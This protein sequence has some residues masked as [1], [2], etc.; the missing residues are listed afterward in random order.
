MT[1]TTVPEPVL[2]P[3]TTPRRRGG[4]RRGQGWAA[5]FFLIPW[6]AGI[7]LL[8][9]GPM[10]YSLYLSFTSYD[11]LSAPEWVGLANYELMLADPRFW[12]SVRVTLVYVVV[13][14]PLLQVVSMLVALL[15][16]S[17]LRFLT[18]YRALFYLPS[19]MG[20]SVAVAALW[21]QVFGAEGLVNA[22]L[23]VFGVEGVGSWV[24]DPNRALG[25]IIGL[26]LWAFG[27]TMIIYL[28]GLRQVPRELL[29]AAEVDGASRLRR[30]FSVTL[31]LMTPLAFF[32]VLMGTINAFQSFTGAYVVSGGTGGPV[33]STLFYTLYLYERG[34][35]QLQMGY[36]SAMA[37][38]LLVVLAVV[39][40]L[41]FRSSRYWVHY[42]DES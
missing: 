2:A 26:N 9:V 22:V 4:G 41:F 24:G 21:R 38:I 36:A 42:G 29:E 8:T 32:N 3:S 13:F 33:D 1:I 40:G 18:G 12:K 30:F 5:F 7:V 35:T 19:L 31:P 34:F 28:A 17:R 20:A 6:G 10:L 25:T 39:T 37:W 11:L 14:V 27:S 15:L 16:N 23:G